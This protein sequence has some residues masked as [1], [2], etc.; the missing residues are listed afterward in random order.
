MGMG[1]KGMEGREW[2]GMEWVKMYLSV[3]QIRINN[4]DEEHA[5][6]SKL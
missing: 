2:E 3:Q 1:C 4:E 6:V 5:V